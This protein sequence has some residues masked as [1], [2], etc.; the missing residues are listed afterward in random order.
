MYDG[1]TRRRCLG[2]REMLG[3]GWERSEKGWRHPKG[4]RNNVRRGSRRG[5]QT[6]AGL[7]EVA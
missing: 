1:L 5:S 3:V 4:I 7:E 2:S 6:A